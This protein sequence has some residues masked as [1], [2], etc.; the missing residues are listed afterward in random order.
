MSAAEDDLSLTPYNKGG[1]LS[2]G[3]AVMG[4]GLTYVTRYHVL[5]KEGD[6]YDPPI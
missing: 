4:K 3:A 6:K 2:K 1:A 5:E